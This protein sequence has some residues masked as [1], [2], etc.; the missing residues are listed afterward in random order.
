MYSPALPAGGS[1]WTDET[2]QDTCCGVIV[3]IFNGGDLCMTAALSAPDSRRAL[4]IMVLK[5]INVMVK[6]C[7]GHFQAYHSPSSDPERQLEKSA[8]QIDLKG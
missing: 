3:N 8:W 7:R 5:G 1:R 6:D 4:D 2:I